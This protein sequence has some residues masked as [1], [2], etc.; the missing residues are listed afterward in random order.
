MTGLLLLLALASPSPTPAPAARIVKLTADLPDRSVVLVTLQARGKVQ[1]LKDFAKQKLYVGTNPINLP[2]SPD[3]SLTGDG[4]EARFQLPYASVPEAVLSHDPHALP[5]RWEAL[6]ASGKPVLAAEG[7]VDLGDP[8]QVSFS[9]R[10]A[11]ELFARLD[12]LQLAP[13]L[14]QVGFS[15]LLSL[16]NPFSFELVVKRIEYEVK[17]GETTLLSAN[18]PGMR[19]RPGRAND[20]LLEQEVPLASLGGAV[21]SLL[22]NPSV[23]FS[24]R[25]VLRTPTGDQVIPLQFGSH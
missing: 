1:K 23:D 7:S 11:Y 25:L 4:F 5:L 22:N 20:V 2:G 17:V 13:G 24:G 12:R 16:Y 3:V 18:R 9:P 14:A 19:L 10:R 8:G 21:Q 15:A 6:D